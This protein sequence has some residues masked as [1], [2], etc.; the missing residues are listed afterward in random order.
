[1]I[2]FAEKKDYINIFDLWN[3][4]FSEDE[5]F[6]NWF[7][8]NKFEFENTLVY[9]NN[10]EILAMLQ[11]IPYKLKNIG[12]VTYIYG[13]CTNPKYR[14]NGIMKEMFKYLSYIDKKD[15]FKASILIPQENWLFDFYDK[16]EYKKLFYIQNEFIQN[17]GNINFLYNFRSCNTNDINSLNCLYEYCL[18]DSNYV[19]RDKEY[20]REQITMFEYLGGKVYCIE[21]D[22]D[23]KAYSFLWKNN[24]LWIQELMSCDRKSSIELYRNIMKKYNF[25]KIRISYPYKDDSK[26]VPFGCIK[27]YNE[28]DNI[29]ETNFYMNL[30]FN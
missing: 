2:R 27:F 29:Y 12:N 10:N 13:V 19:I 5:N 18:K 8:T 1:M 11:R 16:F 24:G 28:N 17:T 22:N 4:C 23:I 14:K 6:S 21:D 20:W 7:F 30:M 26:K 25:S 15:N 9:E 3:I